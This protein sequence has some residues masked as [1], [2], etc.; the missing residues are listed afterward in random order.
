MPELHLLGDTIRHESQLKDGLLPSSN[1]TIEEEDPCGNC[2][3]AGYVGQC[4]KTCDDVKTAYDK[5]GWIFQPQEIKQCAKKVQLD[6]WKDQNADTGGC[7]IYGTLELNKAAGHFHISPHKKLLKAGQ[8]TALVDFLELISFT[9][10][11]FNITHQVN[12]LRFGYQ[13]PGIKSPLDGRK[14]N[15]KDT[16]GMYQYYIKVIPTIYKD[17]MGKEYE[18]N[19]YAVTEHMRHLAPGI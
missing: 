11:Q 12:H 13:Y 3:G 16:H 7:Q 6:N 9:F 10:S 8:Q 17:I 5:K 18:S 4:C 15:V 14:R 2:Y 1:S 19:Q